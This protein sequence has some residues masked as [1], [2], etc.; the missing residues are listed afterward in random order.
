MKYVAHSHSQI[1]KFA[2]L[3]RRTFQLSDECGQFSILGATILRHPGADRSRA[4]KY[5]EK[6][7]PGSPRMRGDSGK[8]GNDSQTIRMKPRE[9]DQYGCR[10]DGFIRPLKKT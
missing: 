8:D 5:G 4:E 10:S 6:K 9:R 1:F 3:W 2:L 7:V